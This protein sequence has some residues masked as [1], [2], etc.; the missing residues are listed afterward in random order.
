MGT[1]AICALK[2]N[3]AALV[4]RRENSVGI[5]LKMALL[6]FVQS[7]SACSYC[8]ETHACGVGPSVLLALLPGCS[9]CRV[10]LSLTVAFPPISSRFKDT[11]VNVVGHRIAERSLQLG[12][13]YPAPEALKFGLVDELVPEEKLQEKA[14]AVMAQWLALPGK[15]GTSDRG[16]GDLIWVGRTGTGAGTW[17]LCNSFLLKGRCG[18]LGG[19]K[20]QHS[21]PG[22]LGLTEMGLPVPPRGRTQCRVCRACGCSSAHP[23]SPAESI[24]R[25]LSCGYKLNL[26]LSVEVLPRESCHGVKGTGWVRVP[27]WQPV[28]LCGLD[29]LSAL[30]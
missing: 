24:R 16:R 20:A 23:A 7:G 22:S 1:A 18:W 6:A 9:C 26:C 14:M 13:L 3:R 12:S 21:S 29:Q 2:V 19:R 25:C 27:G 5:V 10:F 17:D 15:G 11:F 4:E 8:L 28:C 30:C